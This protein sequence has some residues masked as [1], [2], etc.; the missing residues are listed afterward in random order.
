MRTHV[1]AVVLAM[2]ACSAP[3][4]LPPAST[5]GTQ[6]RRASPETTLPPEFR[7][8]SGWNYLPAPIATRTSTGPC[9]QA[10]AKLNSRI[11]P[12]VEDSRGRW[13]FTG[14]VYSE[15]TSL[16]KVFIELTFPDGTRWRAPIAD[17]TPPD[18]EYGYEVIVLR[19]DI[20][21]VTALLY[22]VTP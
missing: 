7:A 1:I 15:G 19:D 8:A 22:A 5:T 9:G 10:P 6:E 4:A 11:D 16:T 20:L 12:P 18:R 3:V 2:I 17:R 14:C 13:R 21:G